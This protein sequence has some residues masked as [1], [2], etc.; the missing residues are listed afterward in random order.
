MAFNAILTGS[1]ASD[2]SGD[3]A[4]NLTLR[5]VPSVISNMDFISTDETLLVSQAMLSGFLPFPCLTFHSLA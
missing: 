1:L 2:L 4:L 5:Q 3:E